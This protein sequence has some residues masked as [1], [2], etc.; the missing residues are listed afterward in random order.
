MNHAIERAHE[1]GALRA[2]LEDDEIADAA[3]ALKR[4][5]AEREAAIAII[6]GGKLAEWETG[7]EGISRNLSMYALASIFAAV[8]SPDLLR[9]RVLQLKATLQ[10]ALSKNYEMWN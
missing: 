10:S 8:E 2:Y 5:D 6:D 9:E 3:A 1:S 4:E 7:Y